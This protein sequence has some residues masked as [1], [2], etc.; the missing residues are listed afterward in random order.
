MYEDDFLEAQYDER[1]GDIDFDPSD[2]DDDG[3]CDHVWVAG[4]CYVHEEDLEYTAEARK[5]F[6]ETVKCECCDHVATEGID[7]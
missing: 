3:P 4:M 7:Y 1:N 5:K 6:G 2:E